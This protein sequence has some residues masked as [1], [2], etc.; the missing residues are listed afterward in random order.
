MVEF[1]CTWIWFTQRATGKFGMQFY[2]KVVN[3]QNVYSNKT[4]L[5]LVARLKV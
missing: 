3:L 2:F 5:E 4:K 1:F